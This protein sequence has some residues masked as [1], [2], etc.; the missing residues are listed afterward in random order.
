M[1][2][3]PLIPFVLS[4]LFAFVSLPPADAQVAIGGTISDG[5]GGPL[6]SG[7]VY[8]VSSSLT[9][10]AGLTLT[11][12]AGAV[13]KFMAAFQRI[14]V[15]GTLNVTASSSNRAIFTRIEDDTAGGDTN[16]DG[17]ATI[18]SPGSWRGVNFGN[19]AGNGTLV[20]LD[21][22][23]CGNLSRAAIRVFGPGPV[24]LSQC[25]FRNYSNSAL[26]CNN[27]GT[28][29]VDN[30]LF[31]DGDVPGKT[32]PVEAI[33]GFTNNTA[34][35]NSI[36]NSWPI[37]HGTVDA[38]QTIGLV[39][40]MGG[41]FVLTNSLTIGTLAT[42]TLGPGVNMKATTSF[43]RV[44]VNGTLV[45]NGVPGSEV[46][47][48]V[49]ADDSLGGD[50]NNDGPSSGTSGT[51]RGVLIAATESGSSFSNTVFSFAGN[52]GLPCLSVSGT[53]PT[54]SNC[55]FSDSSADGVNLN[56]ISNGAIFSNCSF[57]RNSRPVNGAFLEELD[58]F[59]NCIGA[60]NTTSNAIRATDNM[61]QNNASLTMNN[62]IGGAVE[63]ASSI[64]VS[65]GVTWTI[66]AGVVL[67]FN[68]STQSCSVSGMLMTNGTSA[69]PVVFTVLADDVYGGDTNNDG[70]STGAPGSH[71]G[72]TFSS[73]S[74]GS[75][76]THT[77]VRFGG[78]ITLPGITLVNTDVT[79]TNC[80]IE[81]GSAVGLSLSG[82]SAPIVSGCNFDRNT[83]PVSTTTIEALPGF[84][85]NTAAGNSIY[86]SIRNQD[87]SLDAD[88]TIAVTNLLGNTLVNAN[89]TT[90]P[91]GV[92]LTL[93][94]D[95][96]LKH[97]VSS[98]SVSVFGSLVCLGTS[99]SPV[100]LT[101]ILDDANG[102][103]TNLDGGA[104]TP[105]PGTWRGVNLAASSGPHVLDF[106]EIRYAGNINL[107]SLTVGVGNLV[108]TNCKIEH[109]AAAAL[110]F[111]NGD[112]SPIIRDCSFN[113]CTRSMDSLRI[114]N[115]KNLRDDIASGN[116][117]SDSP[118]ITSSVVGLDDVIL[119]RSLIGGVAIT[120]AGISVTVSNSLRIESGCIFKATTSSQSFQVSGGVTQILGTG[121]EPVVFTTIKDDFFGG[122]TNLDGP[123]VG[124]LGQWRGINVAGIGGAIGQIKHVIVR[125]AGN[126]NI[127]GFTSTSNSF[128]IDSIRAEH[129]GLLGIKLSGAFGDVDNLIAF[130][131]ANGIRL[132]GGSF[133]L[134]HATVTGCSAKG[135][136]VLGA[137]TGLI[138]NSI[139]YG[140][141]SNFVGTTALN[142]FS[143]NGDSNLVGINGN[144]DVDPMFVD[145]TPMVG[146]LTLDPAS[147]CIGTADFFVSLS[148]GSDFLD[149]TRV[150]DQNLDGLALSDMGA[151]ELA[152]YFMVFAGTP[153]S[154]NTM[155]F[156]MLGPIGIGFLYLGLDDG[157]PFYFHPYGLYLAGDAN[158]PFYQLAVDANFGYPITFPLEPTLVGTRFSVQMVGATA[159]N[160][161]VGSFTN[162]YHGMIQD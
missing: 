100:V 68:S 115:L 9:V 22:R 66:G 59:V 5:L 157:L 30:C 90:V 38:S 17:A 36:H 53:S 109:G 137:F 149:S 11:V 63:L 162:T 147:P 26:S 52:I 154:G 67:K 102:G 2:S 118:R 130:D 104:T 21:I 136:E 80:T 160:L 123:S 79:L 148:V 7:T 28:P 95:V 82:S 121:L 97:T 122:D 110:S 156:A 76:L 103:D 47:F 71:R 45:C 87:S 84:S 138:Q 57:E 153:V 65:A 143:S 48:T 96:V 54:F 70:P 106:C 131:C 37:N 58:N 94:E 89:S 114:T 56:S 145:S 141:G 33:S 133:N 55:S 91:L 19:A 39:N 152:P 113:N 155:F 99:G 14:D 42:L 13:V 18:P 4:V 140:N 24:S 146:D 93:L 116:S 46:G 144:L 134:R 60:N 72:L 85:N 43:I 50:T 86:D 40:Q 161:A 105:S 124:T 77:I 20:G 88:V 34:N 158:A 108:M 73:G 8:H 129:C 16:G 12:E 126:I 81:D 132:E 49:F 41:G 44:F 151:F 51:W 61:I 27:V 15:E 3:F 10:P 98:H 119:K 1:K 69:N 75:V 128:V 23:F 74:S 135:L 120:T 107:P 35:N 25:V 159:G 139:S 92:T 117:L 101:T 62:V 83:I 112:Y 29:L 64:S 150:S 125:F 6:L 78:N 142:L 32:I 111:N 31:I 127:P